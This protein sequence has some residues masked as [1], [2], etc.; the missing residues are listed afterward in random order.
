MIKN[1]TWNLAVDWCSIILLTQHSRETNLLLT[2]TLRQAFKVR[3]IQ[4]LMNLLSHK[5]P[6]LV[7]TVVHIQE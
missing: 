6:I 7:L 2:L 5:L 4:N 1:K 3:T